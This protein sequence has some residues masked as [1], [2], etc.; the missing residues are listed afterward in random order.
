MRFNREQDGPGWVF[1]NNGFML[2][3]KAPQTTMMEQK[4]PDL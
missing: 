4:I 3:C 1:R 2:H